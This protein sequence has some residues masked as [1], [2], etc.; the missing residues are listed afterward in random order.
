MRKQDKHKRERAVAR[1]QWDKAGKIVRSRAG[2]DSGNTYVVASQKGNR[3]L[4]VD[5]DIRGVQTPKI[6]NIKHVDQVMDIASEEWK[7]LMQY[8]DAG[9]QNAMI[10]RWIRQLREETKDV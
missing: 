3:L 5:G 10:R 6:K 1:I 7:R 9:Q 4:I 2:K 8:Q